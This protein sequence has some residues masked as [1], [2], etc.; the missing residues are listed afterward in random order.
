VRDVNSPT[1]HGPVEGASGQPANGTVPPHGEPGTVHV[2]LGADRTRIVLSGEI[3]ADLG[4]D[5]HQATAD[6]E[7]AGLPIEVDTHHVTFMDSSGVAFLAR[8]ATRSHHRVRLLRVP[9]T[10]RFLLE[11]TRIGELL[12]VIDDDDETTFEAR[13]DDS[14]IQ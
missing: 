13:G 7:H 12:D 8:L 3:D 11:V 10:V 2:I 6:A 9:P 14:L 4:T 5:L 1:G